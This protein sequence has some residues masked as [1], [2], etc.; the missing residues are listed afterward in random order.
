MHRNGRNALVYVYLFHRRVIRKRLAGQLGNVFG[1]NDA[2][3]CALVPHKR[4]AVALEIGGVARLLGIRMLCG[5]F[6]RTTAERIFGDDRFGTC[7]RH[8][9]K[10]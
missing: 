3:G 6:I 4:R 2:L 10:R 7:Y 9:P 8:F 1:D 5:I